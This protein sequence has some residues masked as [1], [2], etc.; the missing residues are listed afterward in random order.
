MFESFKSKNDSNW[1]KRSYWLHSIVTATAAKRIS[2]ELGYPRSGE[3]FTA[4]CCMTWESL[5]YKDILMMNSLKYVPLQMDW[6]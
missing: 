1:N 6:K 5:L 4:A 3:A 2:D